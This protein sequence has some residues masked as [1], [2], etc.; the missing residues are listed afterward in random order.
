[1]QPL[2]KRQ[3]A[4]SKQQPFSR[5]SRKSLALLLRQ[6]SARLC[7][8]PP[9]PPQQP[10]PLPLPQHQS[11]A[12]Q[13]LHN[14]P[15]LR[16]RWHRQRLTRLSPMQS[17]RPAHRL[18]CST[19][20][21]AHLRTHSKPTRDYRTMKHT[22]RAW[23]HSFH[24]HWSLRLHPAPISAAAVLI[25]WEPLCKTQLHTCIHSLLN[26]HWLVSVLKKYI[27]WKCCSAIIRLQF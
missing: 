8:A 9:L 14:S 17:P 1:M 27:F 19:T 18:Q 21:W 25:S 24:K 13:H 22:R 6:Q 12:H 5:K 11:Q 10:P 7:Q 20:H 2:R 3:A 15:N 4:S 16:H 23:T 26:T